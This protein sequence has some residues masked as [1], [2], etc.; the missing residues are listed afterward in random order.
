MGLS[1]QAYSEKR[2]FRRMKIDTIVCV[3]NQ[4]GQNFE[5]ICKDLSGA[6]M[7]IEIDQQFPIGT[8]L[9]VKIVPTKPS[10]TAFSTTAEVARVKSHSP[11]LYTIGL[12]IR[13]IHE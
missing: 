9:N 5:G 8:E 2:N 3:T 13:E 1:G 6:G 11:G 4:A 7:L 12:M 10:G